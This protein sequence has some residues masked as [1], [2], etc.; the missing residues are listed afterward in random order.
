MNYKGKKHLINKRNEKSKKKQIKKTKKANSLNYLNLVK[1]KLCVKLKQKYDCN[2]KKYELFLVDYLLNNAN[3]H[4]VT[5]FKDKMISDYIEEFMHR[6]YDKNECEERMPKYYY[7]Y[8]NYLNFFC[9]PTFKDMKLNEIIQNNGEKKAELYYKKNYL[10][11][12]SLDDIK[13]CGFEKNDTES[14]SDSQKSSK[15]NNDNIIFNENIKEKL[16]NNTVLTTISNGINKTMN[17]NIDNEKIE[18][19]CENKYDISND[20]TV[21]DFIDDYQKEI[22][23]NKIKKKESN[24]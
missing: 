9:K 11:A 14:S 7:Y 5:V 17:L 16:D 10:N 19:F 1:K 4:M 18:V 13:N 15:D 24:I 21:V 22:E 8:K 3:C 20:T 12:K 6:K 2:K 23:K